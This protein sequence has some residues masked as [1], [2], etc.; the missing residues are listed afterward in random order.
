MRE[1]KLENIVFLTALLGI[2]GW[3]SVTSWGFSDQAQTYPRLVSYGGFILC[4]IELVV[5]TLTAKGDDLKDQAKSFFASP[6]AYILLFAVYIVA[7][8]LTMGET[9]TYN[10]DKLLPIPTAISMVFAL[11][12]TLLIVYNVGR[13][14]LPFVLYLLLYYVLIYFIGMVIA[15][16]IFVF[17]FLL[18]IGKMKWYLALLSGILVLFFLI[19][20][21]D[22][23]SLRWPDSII[24]PLEMLGF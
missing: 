15:S 13:S 4:A 16:A 8:Y 3:A 24:D 6:L 11:L 12:L 14:I 2:F 1:H 23:M 10:E 5:Y 9:I 17:L 18:F 7:A 22:I 21:E 20:L 19:N